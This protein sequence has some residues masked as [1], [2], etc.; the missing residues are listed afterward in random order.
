MF[1]LTLNAGS[2]SLRFKLFEEKSHKKSATQLT[3]LF[4]GHIDAIGQSHCE[5]RNYSVPQKETRTR[6]A[7]KTHKEAITSALKILAEDQS[8]PDPKEIRKVAHRVVHGGEKFHKPTKLTTLTLRKLKKLSSL[9]PL[10]NP[11]N[12]LCIKAA[13]KQMPKASHTAI[14]DTGF[15]ATL[16]EKAYLYGLPYELYKK[17][18][19]RRYGFHGTSHKF[20]AHKTQKLLRKKNTNII[21][22]HIGNGVSLCAVKNG[23]SVDTTM[24]FTPLEGPLMGTRAG[25][26]DPAILF[27]LLTL[28]PYKKSFKKDPEATLQ[29]LRHLIEK[30]SGMLG[31]SEISSD[32]RKLRAKPKSKGSIRTFET[33]SHQM[34][35]E[36][37]KLMASLEGIPDAIVFTAGIGENAHYLRSSTLKPL[38]SL[39]L[40]LNKKLNV[41]TVTT[42]GPTLISSKNSSIKVYVIPT[43]EALQMAREIM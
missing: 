7:C 8:T 4:S 24:G 43:N 11:A 36:I 42:S 38:A 6:I 14:F 12:L 26:F 25:S 31:L 40:K 37:Y 1:I 39:G 20:V 35:Q 17:H 33:F 32:V 28:P 22:C 34:S 16:P 5:F 30:E 15:H 27:H 9:A 3:L 23:I 13:K 10:H 19:I 29:K 18:Q 41:E 2:S 21:T